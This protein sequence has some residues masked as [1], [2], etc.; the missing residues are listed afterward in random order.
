MA[1]EA[2]GQVG[3]E[4]QEEGERG[5]AAF[6]LEGGVGGG[7]GGVEPVLWMLER[8][9]GFVGDGGKFRGKRE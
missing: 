6:A 3:V 1:R 5:A 4:L 9:V 8:L 2:R 7:V